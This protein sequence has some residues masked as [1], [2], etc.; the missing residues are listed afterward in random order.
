MRFIKFLILLS[1]GLSTIVGCAVGPRTIDSKKNDVLLA[2]VDYFSVRNLPQPKSAEC[3]AND[4]SWQLEN[5]KSVIKYANACARLSNF[6]K[7]ESLGNYIAQ[8]YPNLPWGPFYLSLAAE[9][10]KEYSRALWMIDLAIKK[11]SHMAIFNYQKG[12]IYWQ[13]G[14]YTNAVKEYNIA[15]KENPNFIEPILFLAQLSYK[16]K[17]FKSAKKY[18]M[19]AL[20]VDADNLSATLGL[21]EVNETLGDSKSAVEFYAKAVN[22]S[23]RTLSYRFKLASLYENSQKDYVQALSVY[24]RI[25]T[26]INESRS[27]AEEIPVNVKEKINHLEGLLNQ[28]KVVK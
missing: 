3:P 1:C 6:I 5:I 27:L 11:S 25:Q 26:V 18:F 14:E 2:P 15:I 8:K 13:I 17:D 19:T 9:G 23:P 20:Q 24:K 16:N 10:R 4:K 21:A 7:L 22:M 12:R 28:K